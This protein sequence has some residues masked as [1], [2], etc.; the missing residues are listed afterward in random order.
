MCKYFLQHFTLSSPL[1]CQWPQQQC[2]PKFNMYL[3]LWFSTYGP[4]PQINGSPNNFLNLPVTNSH[5]FDKCIKSGVSVSVT[6]CS[7]T[8]AILTW[9]SCYKNYTGQWLPGL[10]ASQWKITR[11]AKDNCRFSSQVNVQL[12][13]F[14]A[15]WGIPRQSRKISNSQVAED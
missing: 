15:L 7:D 1:L 3:S 6:I 8:V 14:E 13:K 4:Q 9:N 11:F 12:T 5:Y 10:P 2:S